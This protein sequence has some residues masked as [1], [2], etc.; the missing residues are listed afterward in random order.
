MTTLTSTISATFHASAKGAAQQLGLD[1]DDAR[2]AAGVDDALARPYRLDLLMKCGNRLS[3]ETTLQVC[4][5]FEVGLLH[6]SQQGLPW[7][8]GERVNLTVRP[9]DVAAI[10]RTAVTA[11][12]AAA[13]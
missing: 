13:A 11:P 2:L 4:L 12:A 1:V 5:A 7:Y 9:G 10:F 8:T 6:A 3:F